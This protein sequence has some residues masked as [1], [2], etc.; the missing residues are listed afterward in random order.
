M[1]QAGGDGSDIEVVQIVLG[2]GAL[3]RPVAR[4]SHYAVTPTNGQDDYGGYTAVAI[5]DLE[6]QVGHRYNFKYALLP[7]T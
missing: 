2:P 6:T 1:P 4:G 7:N 5:V 3:Y